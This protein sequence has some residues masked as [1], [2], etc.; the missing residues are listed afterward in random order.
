MNCN[1]EISNYET[2]DGVTYYLIH[3]SNNNNKEWT[4]RHRFKDFL[5][6]H[7]I[8][9]RDL[10]VTKDLLPGNVLMSCFIQLRN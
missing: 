5:S 2:I 3:V 9:I 6:L 1:I 10:A 4:V 8:L 7:E